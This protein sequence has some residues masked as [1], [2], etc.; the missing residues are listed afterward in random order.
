MAGSRT[1]IESCSRL[2]SK[3]YTFCISGTVDVNR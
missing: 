3:P 1:C 2:K